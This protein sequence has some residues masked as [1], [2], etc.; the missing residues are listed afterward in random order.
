MNR[1]IN[2]NNVLKGTTTDVNVTGTIIEKI[3]YFPTLTDVEYDYL[4]VGTTGNADFILEKVIFSRYIWYIS[5]NF[6]SR[7]LSKGNL[8]IAVLWQLYCL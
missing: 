5:Q 6:Q 8:H 3:I 7:Y 4:E 2:K 1:K